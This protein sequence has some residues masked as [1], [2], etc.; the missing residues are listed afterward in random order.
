MVLRDARGRGIGVTLVD[1]EGAGMGGAAWD[2]GSVLADYLACWVESLER[3]HLP[4]VRRPVHAFWD[5][6]AAA[7][8][9]SARAADRL[10]LAA[11]RHAGAR[12][13]QTAAEQAQVTLHLTDTT[14]YTA[15]VGTNVLLRPAEAL[16]RLLGLPLGRA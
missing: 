13:L 9:L 8:G 5:A 16:V 14:L 1:W 15:Q 10:L 12:L 7:A 4:R 3:L 11:A 2:V 6:Y